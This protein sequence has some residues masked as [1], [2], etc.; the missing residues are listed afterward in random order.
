MTVIIMI[1]S[2]SSKVL[3]GICT[4]LLKRISYM[5][6][7]FI[8]SIIALNLQD[9]IYTYIVLLQSLIKIWASLIIRLCRNRD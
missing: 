5:Q 3:Y 7:Y 4:I 1:A 6:S 2:S 9:N 8:M